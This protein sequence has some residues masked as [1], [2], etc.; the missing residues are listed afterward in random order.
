MKLNWRER[1]LVTPSEAAEILSI[2]RSKFY[3]LLAAGVIESV[4]IGRSRRVPTAALLEF[5]EKQKVAA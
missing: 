3:A 1:L 4:S 5:L 2:S